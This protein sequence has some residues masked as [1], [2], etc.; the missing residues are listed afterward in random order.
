MRGP[1][2]AAA[3]NLPD[4]LSITDPTALGAT[5]GIPPHRGDRTYAFMPHHVSVPAAD[6]KATCDDVSLLF[7]DPGW[8]F[9]RVLGELGRNR[10]LI[11]EAMHGAIPA[12]VDAVRITLGRI[13]KNADPWISKDAVFD[14]ACTRLQEALH[15]MTRDAR[16]RTFQTGF[17]C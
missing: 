11:T 12:L 1:L 5:L 13:L 16:S 10:L 7:I 9:D 15:R 8:S 2:T 3:L 14:R 4:E 17:N 6:W